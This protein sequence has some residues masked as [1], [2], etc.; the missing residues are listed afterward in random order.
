MLVEIMG[1]APFIWLF[2]AALFS[3]PL[4]PFGGGGH[5]KISTDNARVPLR[6]RRGEAIQ[7]YDT[8]GK[9]TQGRLK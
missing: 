6:V 2:I 1:V 3:I 5:E 8:H 7:F 9:K 4:W